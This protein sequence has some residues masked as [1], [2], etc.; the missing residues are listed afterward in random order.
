VEHDYGRI[1]NNRYLV[2]DISN[3]DHQKQ[4]QP[5]PQKNVNFLVDYVDGKDAHSIVGLQSARWPIG[6][7]SAFCN[8]WK[9]FS[10]WIGTIF[11]LS[12]NK[13]QHVNAIS[14]KL[15]T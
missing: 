8:C 7:E 4:T 1:E 3:G 5:K 2:N 12:V 10:H 9:N 15:I 6:V 11:W 13:S 14:G